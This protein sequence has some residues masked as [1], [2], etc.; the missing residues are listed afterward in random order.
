MA[1]TSDNRIPIWLDC[2]PGQDDLHAIIMA[3]FHPKLNLLG[4]S[5]VHG[6]TILENTFKNA[7]RVLKVCGV[8]DIKVYAGA[9]KVNNRPLLREAKNASYIHG[10]TGLD[11]SD[12]LPEADLSLMQTGVNGIQAMAEAI[13]AHP[14]PVVLAAVGPLTNI[15]LLVSTYPEA[16]ANIREV[17]LMGG[18]IAFGN[19]TPVAEFNVYADPEALQVVLNAGLNRVVMV[20]LDCTHQSKYTPEKQQ[21]FTDEISPINANFAKMINDLTNFVRKMYVGFGV[22]PNNINWHDA[23]A[24]YHCIAPETFKDVN[25]YVSTVYG[26]GVQGEGQTI[27]DSKGSTGKAVNC[28]VAMGMNDD[29]FFEEMFKAWKLAAESSIL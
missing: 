23:I 13:I 1:S 7:S 24:V 3:K 29:L 20:P 12:L 22:D 15:A 25:M 5:T 6:N 11:G 2:D 19:T 16:K 27:G 8:S 26:H 10:V 28:V 18:G 9:P 21:K 4:I 17:L 14:E